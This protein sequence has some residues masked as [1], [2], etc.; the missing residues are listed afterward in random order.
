[1]PCDHPSLLTLCSTVVELRD[2]LPVKGAARSYAINASLSCSKYAS[3]ASFETTFPMRS[4]LGLIAKA[5]MNVEPIGENSYQIP[6]HIYFRCPC[7]KLRSLLFRRQRTYLH[8]KFEMLLDLLFSICFAASPG[9]LYK[10]R[11]VG[12]RFW[13][14]RSPLPQVTAVIF[15]HDNS[16]LLHHA[17]GNFCL[18]AVIPTGHRD[19]QVHMVRC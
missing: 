3:H 7:L 6:M 15:N 1:M 17:T 9:S 2:L 16:Y 14:S 4:V 18:H 11:I 5:L 19:G 13:L 12:G 8:N 10:E